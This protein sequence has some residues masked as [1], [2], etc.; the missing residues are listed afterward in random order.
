MGRPGQNNNRVSK[1]RVRLGTT[2]R[3][4]REN[5]NLM[6]NENS[7]PL[8]QPRQNLTPT[9]FPIYQPPV[10]QT[11][12]Y[13]TYSEYPRRVSYVEQPLNI[14]VVQSR[15]PLRQMQNFVH[16]EEVENDLPRKIFEAPSNL[17]PHF[18]KN[19]K[20]SFLVN[21]ILDENT[22]ITHELE[23]QIVNFTMD[24]LLKENKGKLN[25]GPNKV[26]IL[27][28]VGQSIVRTFPRLKNAIRR[29]ENPLWQHV[30]EFFL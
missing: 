26:E 19:L 5:V 27:H 24:L 3:V 9:N 18:N 6:V 10:L 11:Q 7:Q 23:C 1:P 28:I 13:P 12:Q 22:P 25:F 4:S 20:G 21:K 17:L 30:R 8:V 29:N 14:S 16:E 15:P 2:Q